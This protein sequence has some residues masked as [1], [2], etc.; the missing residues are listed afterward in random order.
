MI[1][2]SDSAALLTGV[3]E[4]VPQCR[5]AFYLDCFHCASSGSSCTYFGIRKQ[6]LIIG[7]LINR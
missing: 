5:W 7:Y 3:A 4:K 6:L 2:I 1:V